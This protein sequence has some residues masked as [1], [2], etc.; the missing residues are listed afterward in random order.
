MKLVHNALVPLT[1]GVLGYII[2]DMTPMEEMIYSRMTKG[3]SADA[4]AADGGKKLQ[5]VVFLSAFIPFV[6][7][8]VIAFA[9]LGYAFTGSMGLATGAGGFIGGVGAGAAL[10]KGFDLLGGVSE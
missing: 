6:I 2:A 8:L 5:Q 1:G 4:L 7:Y 9:G 3:M 10:N